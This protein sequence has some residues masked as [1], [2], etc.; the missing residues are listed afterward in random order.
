MKFFCVEIDKSFIFDLRIFTYRT[1]CMERI[2]FVNPNG[3]LPKYKYNV[4]PF[5]GRKRCFPMTKDCD[6][7]LFCGKHLLSVETNGAASCWSRL[8]WVGKGGG[9][10]SVAWINDPADP[11]DKPSRQCTEEICPCSQRER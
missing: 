10:S 11:T 5:E 3:G 8:W 7:H 9:G 6:V 1:V 2:S 4:T